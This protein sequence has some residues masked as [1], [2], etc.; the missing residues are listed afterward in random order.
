[1]ISAVQLFKITMYIESKY[2]T[3]LLDTDQI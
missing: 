1:L 3:T 2:V